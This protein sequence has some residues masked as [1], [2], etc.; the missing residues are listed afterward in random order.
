MPQH[1]LPR[2]RRFPQSVV[3]PAWQLAAVFLTLTLLASCSL[4]FDASPSAKSA[5]PAPTATSTSP[6]ATETVYWSRGDILFALRASDG[7]VLWR[8]P[9]EPAADVVAFEVL[10]IQLSEGVGT[11][12]TV[13]AVVTQH[14]GEDIQHRVRRDASAETTFPS[15]DH[16]PGAQPVMDLLRGQ[17]EDASAAAPPAT[18]APRYTPGVLHQ[19]RRAAAG[20]TAAGPTAP[21]R[22][23]PPRGASR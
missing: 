11:S 2:R 14:V 22:N 21:P 7:A 8:T 1:D 3:R 13:R 16:W 17:A 18:T 20:D 5:T 19:D 4:P 10:T 23:T 15:P 6:L 9:F 12:I